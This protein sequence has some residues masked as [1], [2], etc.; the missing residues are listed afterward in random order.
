MPGCD[1]SRPSSACGTGS[2]PA[3]LSSLAVAAELS[4]GTLRAVPLT[5]VD[6][7]RTLR[8]VWTAGRRLT[9]PARDLYAIAARSARRA[10]T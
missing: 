10:R 8:V 4:A 6:L 2:G 3:V 1:C 7:T 9:G 5:G